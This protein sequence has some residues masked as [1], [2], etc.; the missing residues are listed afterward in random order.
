MGRTAGKRDTCSFEK[1]KKSPQVAGL[2]PNLE[3][4][5]GDRCN[6]IAVQQINELYYSY[7]CHSRNIYLDM[8]KSSCPAMSRKHMAPRNHKILKNPYQARADVEAGSTNR[9]KSSTKKKARD[10]AVAG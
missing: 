10:L 1:R 5:G 3:G 4:V 6:Y 7:T 8:Q 2:N 9:V